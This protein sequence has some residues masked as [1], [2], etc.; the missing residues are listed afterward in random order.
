M[1]SHGLEYTRA[2]RFVGYI[3]LSELHRAP[4]LFNAEAF[5]LHETISRYRHR[6]FAGFWCDLGSPRVDAKHVA[7]R[8]WWATPLGLDFWT[9]PRP[10]RC[11]GRPSIGPF[12]GSFCHY[13]T[14]SIV[15]LPREHATGEMGKF[16]RVGGLGAHLPNPLT[17][18][19]SSQTLPARV[20]AP[21][22]SSLPWPPSPVASAPRAS[23][24]RASCARR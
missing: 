8:Q 24:S 13:C 19:S 10:Y 1:I 17:H 5:L 14:R 12:P 11:V 23:R 9:L 16:S 18:L 4:I 7:L 3:R 6:E 2:P 21:R 20:R 22:P 15:Q